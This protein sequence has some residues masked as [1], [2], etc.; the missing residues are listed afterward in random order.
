M[1][2]VKILLLILSTLLTLPNLAEAKSVDAAGICMNM[3]LSFSADKDACVDRLRNVSYIQQSAVNVCKGLS[4][5]ADKIQCLSAVSDKS[6]SDSEIVFCSSKSFAADKL[7]C[8]SANGDVVRGR[9]TDSERLQMASEL[10]RKLR[11]QINNVQLVD[12]I[13]TLDDLL[14]V[15]EQN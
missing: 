14:W 6:Y 8:L 7:S 1:K 15:L 11:R 13:S 9:Y 10:A 2:K 12:A 3:N 5:A 4:F